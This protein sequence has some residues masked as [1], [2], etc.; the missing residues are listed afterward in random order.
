M[1]FENE[2]N[3]HLYSL[4]RKFSPKELSALMDQAIMDLKNRSVAGA[5]IVPASFLLGG[6][7][8]D[9]ASEQMSLFI[10]IGSI[11]SVATL[12]RISAIVAFSRPSITNRHSWIAVFFWS[13]LFMGISWGLFSA[14]SAFFYHDS[15]HIALIII[16]LAGI[17]GGSM[18][19]Y[20]IW[21]IL[22]Y[23]YLLS[24]LVPTVLVE[25]YIGNNVTIPIGIAVSF[26]LI[27]NLVQTKIWNKHYWLS[28]INEF[29]V[30]SN[31]I[32][33][34]KLNA[35]LSDEILEH[36]QT[37]KNIAVS[38]KK[39]Q[40]IYNS[41]HDGIFIF[42]LSGQVI[43][44][45]E[46]MLK[47]FNISRQ[48]ALKFD[49]NRSFQSI[50]NKNV[51]LATIWKEALVGND[52]EF[53]WLTRTQDRDDYS[54]VQVN[55]KRSQWGDD[56]VI[57]ATVRDITF[58]VEAMRATS[59]ANHAKSEFI[60][61]ISHELR[62][63]IHG[64]LGYARLGAKRFEV[65][66]KHKINEYFTMIQESGTRLMTLLDN[67]L[68]FSKLE[69]GKMRYTMR[70]SDLLPRIHQVVREIKAN[71]AEKEL[72]FEIKC[73]QEQLIA[74]Y[75]Q[76]K[77]VQ[78]LRNLLF[79]A[80]KFSN[81]QSSIQ[82]DCITLKLEDH[83]SKQQISVTNQGI[84]IPKDELITIFDKFI[85]SSTTNTGAGGTGLGLAISKQILRDHNSIIWAE[86]SS[87]G[88]TIFRFL[89]PMGEIE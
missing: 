40:D 53:T 29:V 16:I 20:C 39:L 15:L 31:A 72:K 83:P 9:Y 81:E 48:D 41:A 17:G 80:V 44:I 23:S 61:N 14:T 6:F 28:L 89:L 18:V 13:N 58:Q 7:A 68:D 22:S 86:N 3:R 33:L 49:I 67:V 46:T 54:T 30:Q 87:D 82:I 47:M 85:Q 76:E 69:I 84:A 71:A 59:A 65:L 42:E 34:K 74:F 62:T 56:S 73:E 10:F 26:F 50:K 77:I 70:M 88:K 36:K 55:L 75:D 32:E 63:P 38:S 45:N 24:I 78:V 52:Q 27:F 35:Q 8:T 25:F 4:N 2:L 51:D 11:L 1:F 57:I 12:I 5:V 21:E 79:N 37:A 19:S 66:P 64:I 60:A 43:D